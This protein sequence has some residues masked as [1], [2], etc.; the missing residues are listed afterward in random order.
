MPVALDRLPRQTTPLLAAAAL[1]SWAV[2]LWQALP[3]L[4]AGPI[5]S[6]QQDA[7]SLAGH[8][9]AC[10]AAAFLS[11]AFLASLALSVRRGGL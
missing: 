3:R 9:P 8:C 7:F 10:F 6:A 5:C 2:A 11:M 4:T 1:S